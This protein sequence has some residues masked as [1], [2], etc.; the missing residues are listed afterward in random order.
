MPI[1]HTQVCTFLHAA[2]ETVEDGEQQAG[3]LD[4]DQEI[5]AKGGSNLQRIHSIISWLIAVHGHEQGAY[6]SVEL[7]AS[8]DD[9]ERARIWQTLYS[10]RTGRFRSG[11]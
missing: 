5:M 1:T 3:L 10:T 7:D 11:P 6:H 2:K 9:I 4:R 8:F